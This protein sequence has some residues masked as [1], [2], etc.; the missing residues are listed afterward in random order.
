VRIMALALP[1]RT[2]RRRH[3][4]AAFLLFYSVVLMYFLPRR[5]RC[6]T[7]VTTSSGG[8]LG[9]GI[10]EGRSEMRYAL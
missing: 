8:C 2:D 5:S 7:E 4:H 3:P 10:D 6:G 9:S 1:Y